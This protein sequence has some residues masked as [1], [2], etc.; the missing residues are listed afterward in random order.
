MQSLSQIMQ[1]THAIVQTN[2]NIL[3]SQICIQGEI[4]QEKSEGNQA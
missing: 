3:E 1:H 4:K 2:F